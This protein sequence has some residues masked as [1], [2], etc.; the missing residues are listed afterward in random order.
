MSKNGTRAYNASRNNTPKE[1]TEEIAKPVDEPAEE[2][3]EET[4]EPADESV[5]EIEEETAKSVDEYEVV[6]V[7][8]CQKLRI[9]KAPTTEENNV[10]KIITAGTI[11]KVRKH[12]ADWSEIKDGGFVM[13][14]FIVQV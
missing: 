11:L 4:I 6:K 9:R 3:T 7:S 5:E 14:K 1:F 2:I 10:V 8:G 13:S 12:N